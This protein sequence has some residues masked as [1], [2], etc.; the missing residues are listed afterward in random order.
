M[1]NDSKNT[2]VVT[3]TSVIISQGT[4]GRLEAQCWV[5]ISKRSRVRREGSYLEYL[6]GDKGS[7]CVR[8]NSEMTTQPSECAGHAQ[9]QMGTW[10]RGQL[11]HCRGR[12]LADGKTVGGKVHVNRCRNT[13]LMWKFHQ[14][15]M[16]QIV[17]RKWPPMNSH[18]M[19]FFQKQIL[20]LQLQCEE[21]R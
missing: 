9:K 14:Q 13:I 11:T 2:A 12:K 20:V 10:L 21:P 6:D 19:K 7:S 18:V 1:L 17:Y 4:G 16:I 8:L 3:H 5:R 15:Y